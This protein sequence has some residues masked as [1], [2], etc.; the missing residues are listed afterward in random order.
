MLK[1]FRFITSI[2]RK[3]TLIIVVYTVI[4]LLFGIFTKKEAVP[5]EHARNFTKDYQKRVY[6]LLQDKEVRKTR[7]GQISMLLYR[8]S[9]CS[10]MGIACTNNP[11]D[12]EKYFNSSLLGMTTNIISAPYV[13]PPASG[14]A[15]IRDGLQQSN[16]IPQTYAA[17]GIGFASIKS[18]VRIWNLFRNLTYMI[19]VFITVTIGFLIMFRVKISAQTVI[20]IEN[21]IP[22]IFMTLI[23]IT[24]SFAIAGILIDA[25]YV[26]TGVII[27]LFAQLDLE[28]TILTPG[29]TKDLVDSYLTAQFGA[30]WPYKQTA[31]L[32]MTPIFQTGNAF[33]NV[34]PGIFKEAFKFITAYFFTD[35]AV[36]KLTQVPKK[37]EGMLNGIGVEIATLGLNTGGIAKV[38]TFIVEF[39]IFY[40]IA[41][42]LPG[43]IIGI[44]MS[45]TV[46]LLLLKIFVMVFTAYLKIILLII[47]APII[48]ALE[49]IP[50]QSAFMDWVKSLFGELL[51]FP[52]L[53]TFV[54]SGYAITQLQYQSGASVFSLPFIY[55]MDGADISI[56]TGMA[57][58][59]VADDL[60]NK[61]KEKLGMKGGI[62]IPLSPVTFF[63]PTMGFTHNARMILGETFP[64]LLTGMDPRSPHARAAVEAEDSKHVNPL[65]RAAMGG[66]ADES[67]AKETRE[68]Q[69]TGGG[70]PGK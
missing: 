45:F 50:G 65:I 12:E 18:Y 4:A 25:M 53:I 60:V 16:F 2:F 13:N 7:P 55:G 61:V 46:F 51:T 36:D 42:W 52:L 54:L 6:T 59:F 37:I 63:G 34:L 67:A 31:E 33:Y 27:S 41:G 38:L 47:F 44:L 35:I 57:I 32:G 20:S 56:I 17:E 14:L 5:N 39:A 11:A 30:V 58:L 66:F 68:V 70:K 69:N 48:I 1:R 40:T 23:F 21:S 26:I 22:R 24:F 8:A 9:L 19:L 29:N 62:P 43:I 10:V 49:A 28:G 3:L 64:S 15:W